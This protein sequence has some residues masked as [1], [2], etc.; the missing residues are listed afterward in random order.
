MRSRAVISQG[1]LYFYVRFVVL[2]QVDRQFQ[3][4]RNALLRIGLQFAFIHGY[5][6][7]I[8]F[9]RSG[10]GIF[11]IPVPAVNVKRSAAHR[12]RL[13]GRTDYSSVVLRFGGKRIGGGYRPCRNGYKRAHY[14]D[15]EQRTQ[16]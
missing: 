10:S 5:H 2:F 7:I 1:V 11:L 6:G 16:T 9:I 4:G 8:A 13:D 12:P 3:P 14:A 15:N